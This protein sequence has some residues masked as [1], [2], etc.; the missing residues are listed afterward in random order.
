L[1]EH[2]F[3]EFADFAVGNGT[4]LSARKRGEA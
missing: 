2:G 3:A 1:S 4:A